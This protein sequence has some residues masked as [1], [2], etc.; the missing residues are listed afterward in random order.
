V[1]LSKD[2]MEPS[3]VVDMDFPQDNADLTYNPR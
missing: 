3:R 1:I 2:S